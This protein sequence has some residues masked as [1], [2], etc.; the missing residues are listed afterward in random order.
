MKEEFSENKQDKHEPEMLSNAIRCRQ[1]VYQVQKSRGRSCT[2]TAN[3]QNTERLGKKNYKDTVKTGKREVHEDG[4]EL[5]EKQ[6]GRITRCKMDGDRF[7][8]E[9]GRIVEIIV[10]LVL[11]AWARMAEE[12]LGQRI[13]L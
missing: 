2:S 3:A 7:F 8:M 5:I 9:E 10:D 6:E 13:P 11:Q 1:K 12:S 4:E